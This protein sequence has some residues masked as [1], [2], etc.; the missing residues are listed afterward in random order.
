MAKLSEI[1]LRLNDS[2]PVQER[3]NFARHLAMVIKAGLPVYEGLRIIR[4]QATS[5]TIIR[6]ID[7]LLID[8][9][10][11]R[12]LAD[13]LEKFEHLFGSFYIN[14]IRVG[15]ASG[16]LSQNLLYLSEELRKSK[17]LQ[18]KVRSAMIYPIIILVATIGMTAF[19]AFFVLPKL[20]PMLQGMNVQ[21][22]P[23]T[24][25]LINTIEF[26][27]NYG[28]TTVI[29][30]FVAIFA[31]RLLIR[32]VRAIRYVVHRFIFMLPVVSPL[33]IA[34]NMVTFARVLA[35]LLK[36]GV[37]IVEAV[38]ITGKTFSNLVYQRL[39]IAANDEIK[40]GGQ[41]ATILAHE[42]KFFPPLLSGMIQV[43]EST[44]NLEDNLFYLSEYYDEEVDMKLRNLTSLL[45]PLMLL[46]MGLMVGFV[47]ISI[48][49]PI[50]SLSQGVK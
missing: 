6:V 29:G 33:V 34:V 7:Q 27:R 37:K 2:L 46:T 32:K 26:L 35:M 14:I 4:A 20:L 42:K 49:T 12:F 3:I 8:V 21:L 19:L 23:T 36:S 48:I 17:E 44:G 25:A 40:K 10:N 38:T 13:S 28:I 43:G 31:S 18:S 39:I 9:N 11:G 41:L 47:A 22:P 15:E 50:Y 16:T 45:E 1:W 30:I 24:R 5:R